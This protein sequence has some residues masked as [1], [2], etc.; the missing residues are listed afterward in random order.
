LTVPRRKHRTFFGEHRDGVDSFD[1]RSVSI[2]CEDVCAIGPAM[3]NDVFTATSTP[4][5]R[6]SAL[7]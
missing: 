1:R 4:I 7:R 6:P 5:L 2:A 3:L